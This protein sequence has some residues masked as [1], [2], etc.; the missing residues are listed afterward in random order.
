MDQKTKKSLVIMPFGPT[1][2]DYYQKIYRPALE[3]AGFQVSRADESVQ[4]KI[5]LDEIKSDIKSA[6]LLLADLTG[7]NANVLYE[8]GL[9]HALGKDVILTAKSKRDIPFDLQHIRVI[10]YNTNIPEWGNNLFENVRR[11]AV[12]FEKSAPLL[13]Q[14]PC[15][16]E[17]LYSHE[18]NIN[19]KIFRDFTAG[20]E[21]ALSLAKDAHG[22]IEN[23]DIY[24]LSTQTFLHHILYKPY[25]FRHVRVLLPTIQSVEKFLYFHH[26]HLKIN[27]DNGVQ[28]LEIQIK[29]AIHAWKNLEANGKIHRVSVK[30]I[31]AFP[32]QYFAIFNDK[33]VFNGGYFFNEIGTSYGIGLRRNYIFQEE[34]AMK[35][36]CADWFDSAWSI[37]TDEQ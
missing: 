15:A 8:L 16:A 6:D 35:G 29:E 10:F 5:I 17:L 2:G 26:H 31:N 11:A 36:Y 9:A 32:L 28:S 24:A 21:Y 23:L 22:W 14:S 30:R 18:Q 20:F 27:P 12:N 37:S 33:T 1:I 7:K 19:I 3:A 4:P 34:H 13:P 25:H